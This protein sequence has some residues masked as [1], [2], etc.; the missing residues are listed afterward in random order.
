MQS[1]AINTDGVSSNGS[2]QGVLDTLLCDTVCQWFAAGRWFSPATPV[3]STN[4]ADHHGITEISLTVA[5]DTTTVT[6]DLFFIISLNYIKSVLFIRIRYQFVTWRFHWYFSDI[7]QGF[8]WW[9]LLMTTVESYKV[10]LVYRYN[11]QE[12]TYSKMNTRFRTLKGLSKLD[13]LR[14]W[15]HRIHQ[16]KTNKTDKQ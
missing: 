1:V 7:F 2:W 3:S 16:T 15:K 9:W 11:C 6:P 13:N 4:K 14:N 10:I 12:H 5:F 8:L